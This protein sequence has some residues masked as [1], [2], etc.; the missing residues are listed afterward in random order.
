[1][2]TPGFVRNVSSVFMRNLFEAGT[3]LFQIIYINL[4]NIMELGPSYEAASCAAT[5]EIPKIIRTRRF[6]TVFTRALNWSLS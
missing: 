1:M 6:I 2:T 4:T 3:E 5:Q